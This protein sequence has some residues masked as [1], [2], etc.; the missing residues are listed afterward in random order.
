M[1]AEKLRIMVADAGTRFIAKESPPSW[2]AIKTS[3]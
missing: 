1:V 3:R 2:E